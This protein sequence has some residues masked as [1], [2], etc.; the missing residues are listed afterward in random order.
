MENSQ[1]LSNSPG[2]SQTQ[3]ISLAPEKKAEIVG[4]IEALQKDLAAKGHEIADPNHKADLEAEAAAAKAQ[5]SASR[6][7]LAAISEGLKSIAEIVKTAGPAA[8]WLL[9][10]GE[11]IQAFIASYLPH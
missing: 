2:A 1:I 8:P 4:I 10:H 11:K 7:R 5:L 6:P 3:S 9:A